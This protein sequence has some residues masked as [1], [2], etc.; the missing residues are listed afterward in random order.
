LGCMYSLGHCLNM[1]SA[2]DITPE[3]IRQAATCNVLSGEDA[4]KAA[5]LCVSLLSISTRACGYG[6]E[7][8][9]TK[10]KARS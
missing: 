1:L 9:A 8:V 2:H 6:L 5:D 10:C 3:R 7:G 4:V